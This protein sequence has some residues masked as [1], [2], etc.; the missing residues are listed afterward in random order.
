MYEST[1]GLSFSGHFLIMHLF[2]GYA[3]YKILVDAPRG[4]FCARIEII[5]Y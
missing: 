1:L 4:F 5:H 3:N 2:D